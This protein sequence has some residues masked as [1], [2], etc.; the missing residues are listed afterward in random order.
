MTIQA[1]TGYPFPRISV[2]MP[3]LNEAPNLPH[4]FARLP[5]DIHEVILVDGCSVD[6]TIEVAR[7]LRPDV[8][9]SRRRERARETRL[10]ADLH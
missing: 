8:V 10:P 2:V 4:V 6:G 3:A 9:L 7:R 1:M 5:T